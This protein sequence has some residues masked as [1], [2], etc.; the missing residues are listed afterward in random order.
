M[1]APRPPQMQLAD[2]QL[3]AGHTRKFATWFR[4]VASWY[5]PA[6]NGRL[7]ASGEIYDMYAM[8]AATTESHPQLPLG[9]KVRVVNNHNGRSVV[10]RITDRGPLPR[11]RILDLSYGAAKKLA[12]VKP[13]I[14]N[15]RVHVLRWGTDQ[16]HAPSR[17]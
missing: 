15:V 1:I 2:E 6:F 17:G 5:G 14:A 4:G 7:T 11:G 12:M 9:T 16:Y 3:Y 8:T 13:G 10:V